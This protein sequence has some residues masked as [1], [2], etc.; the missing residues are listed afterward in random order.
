MICNS[1]ETL[2]FEF[3]IKTVLSKNYITA[4]IKYKAVAR[5]FPREGPNQKKGNR[6]RSERKILVFFLCKRDQNLTKAVKT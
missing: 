2:V 4:Y 5:K 1:S 6:E 3:E